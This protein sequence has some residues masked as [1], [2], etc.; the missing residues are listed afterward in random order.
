MRHGH[1]LIVSLTPKFTHF[2]PIRQESMSFFYA[3]IKNLFNLRNLNYLLDISFDMI[4]L[5]DSFHI[6]IDHIKG[7]QLFYVEAIHSHESICN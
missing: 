5:S 6:K 4:T 7:T 3:I 2:L 1:E